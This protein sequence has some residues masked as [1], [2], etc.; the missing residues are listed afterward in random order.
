MRSLLCLLYVVAA[1]DFRHPRHTG[2]LK[3]NPATN[4]LVNSYLPGVSLCV[5]HYL[6]YQPS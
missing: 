4:Y 3:L 1:V 5:S 6:F 2:D